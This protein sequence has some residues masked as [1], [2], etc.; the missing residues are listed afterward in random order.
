MSTD[1][2]VEAVARAGGNRGLEVGEVSGTLCPRRRER[3]K[4]KGELVAG[5]ACKA[6]ATGWQV[7]EN[8][9][10]NNPLVRERSRVQSSPAAP[11]NTLKSLTV[12]PH[13]RS[14]VRQLKAERGTNTTQR[15][16]Q[17]ACN[18]FPAR[19]RP[20]RIRKRQNDTPIPNSDNP[21]HCGKAGHR[22]LCHF[23]AAVEAFKSGSVWR[24]DE[25]DFSDQ[26]DD[27]CEHAGL[28]RYGCRK[29]YLREKA[30]PAIE[31]SRASWAQSAGPG[32]KP[33]E[34]L[35]VSRLGAFRVRR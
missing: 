13:R 20:P 27:Q 33:G 34:L 26:H 1:A 12:K 17:N 8:T 10:L 15:A 11:A 24:Y 30:R 16:V 3:G 14:S 32:T 25:S 7:I 23:M 18:L 21:L 22:N 35:T 31:T 4:P 28:R 5:R 19:S 6:R 9:G 29:M 2:E